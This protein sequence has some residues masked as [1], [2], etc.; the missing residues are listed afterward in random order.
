MTKRSP[1]K[2]WVRL[3][4][5]ALVVAWGIQAIVSQSLLVREA[6]VLMF[7]SEFAWGIVLS[8]WLA[9]VAVGG[10]AGGWI[11]TKLKNPDLGLVAVVVLLS[12]VIC[13]DIWVFRGARASLGVETGELLPLTKTA[14][15]AM[16][17]VSPVGL[18]I[19]LAFPLACNIA[20]AHQ[21]QHQTGAGV[22]GNI[23]AYESAGSLIG[24]AAFT[25][26]AV[27][28]LSPIEIAL[29][30]AVITLA[31]SSC[32]LTATRPTR[33]PGFIFGM[34]AG[35]L[36]AITI[37]HGPKLNQMLIQRRWKIVAPGYE[38]CAETESKYQNLTLGRLAEQY[39]LYCDGQI[40]ANFPDPYSFVPLAHF[41]MCQ[42]PA[43]QKVLVIGGG[44]EG[45]LAEILKHPVEH[46]DYLEPDPRLIKL[47]KPYLTD[48]DRQALDDPRITVHYRDA[49]YFIKTQ[50]NQYHLVI[51]RLPEPTSAL[52]ARFYTDEFFSELRRSMTE[53][54]V[55][56]MT[57]AATPTNLTQESAEYLGSLRATMQAHFPQIVI[58]WDD[59]A[60]VLAAT[61]NNL[62]SAD[63]AVLAQRFKQRNVQSELFDPIWFEGATDWLDARKVK[64]RNA[65]LDAANNLII[66]TDLQPFV[67]IQRLTLWEKMT[68]KEGHYIIHRLRS[69][70]WY[71]LVVILIA[72]TLLT[73]TGYRIKHHSNL[74]WVRGTIVLSIATSGFATMALSIIWLFAFQNLYGYV[75]QRIGWIVALFMG[76]LVI[77]CELT[78]R[79]VD[80]IAEPDKLTG[81]L[82]QRLIAVDLI[83]AVLALGVPFFLPALADLQTSKFT[84]AVVESAVSVVVALT[85]VLG[86]ISFALAGGLQLKTTGQTS[87]AAGSIV[88]ADHTGACVG[89]LLTGIL[90]VPVFG[91]PTAAYLLVG[92][93]IVSVALLAIGWR[94]SRHQKHC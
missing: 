83:I 53:R 28:H 10:A 87:T 67:Y 62:V 44:S 7:G 29:I 2:R 88:A 45:L 26:L 76:G 19:G 4:L 35:A 55:L 30:C 13:A 81:Y 94:I 49:R 91:T 37:F 18:L 1:S 79:Q 34:M 80:R 27:E 42:H 20:H 77:G 72:V 5:G 54:A 41:W 24:G 61:G 66:S 68:G 48:P 65:E 74:G 31:V 82:W 38:L 57:A 51:A 17:F 33:K 22:L 58:G 78:R 21:H 39:T 47:I 84:L 71:I 36:L 25:F 92:I 32:L 14:I 64:Q 40:S 56:C 93:K 86:G 75:Y 50:Q 52:R 3:W 12:A 60:Q 15:A 69:I 11:A 6:L 16:L 9:G 90:L 43:P 63:P 70:N 23:Y 85:G 73:L 89:A 8:S 46:I 59:P